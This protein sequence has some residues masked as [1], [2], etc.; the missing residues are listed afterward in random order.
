MGPG[1][2]QKLR[3]FL[4][5]DVECAEERR[6]TPPV[7][8]QGYDLRVWGRFTNQPRPLGLGWIMN[9]LERHA[10]RGTFFVEALGAVAFG[11][12]GLA[13]ICRSV[14]TRGHD[15]QLHLHPGLTRP[16]WLTEGQKPP[17]DDLAAYDRAAQEALL[18][19]GL[20]QFSA[21][22]VPPSEVVAFRAGNYGANNDTWAAMNAVGLKVSSNLNISY[23]GKS[24][25]IMGHDRTNDVFDTGL[26]VVEVPITN[27]LEPSGRPRLLQITA[28][29]FAELRWALAECH[30][31]GMTAVTLVSHTFEYFFVDHVE[32][33]RGRPNRINQRRLEHLVRHLAENSHRYEVQTMSDLAAL[34]PRLALPR[35]HDPGIQRLPRGRR[36]NRYPRLV[37]QGIK[38][39]LR[40]LPFASPLPPS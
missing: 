16:Y 10:L 1:A 27:L 31:L 20:S 12:P 40:S 9:V 22:D 19:Q 38:R 21:C 13:E 24:C 30:R 17:P 6:G 33:R 35:A 5:F 18:R 2:D 11:V 15:L 7:P 29:S 26:G 32:R 23:L 25:G 37:E 28:L 8:A 36:R 34:V 39:L 3:V 14:R 4:T